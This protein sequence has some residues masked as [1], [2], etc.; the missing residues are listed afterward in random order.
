MKDKGYSVLFVCPTNKLLFNY[1]NSVTFN[2]FFGIGLDDE[3]TTKTVSD[4]YNDYDVIVFDEIYFLADPRKLVR[5]KRF[6]DENPNKIVIA[7]GDTL[8]LECISEITNTQDYDDY[9]N[10]CINTIFPNEVMLNI[11]KRVATDEQRSRLKKV[12]NAIFK[13]NKSFA[14]I[15]K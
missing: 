14:K 4:E 8:Q 1:E 3:A 6:C 7:T 2:K 11:S 12:K 5:I 15:I 9:S 13:N 10:N